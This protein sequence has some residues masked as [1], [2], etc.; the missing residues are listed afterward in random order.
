MDTPR[1]GGKILSHILGVEQDVVD[2]LVQFARP[3]SR[4][5]GRPRVVPR[6]LGIRPADFRGEQLFDAA[7]A[8][9]RA[10]QQ[11]AGFLALEVV[12]RSEPALE[13]VAIRTNEL[14]YDQVSFPSQVFYRAP[15]ISEPQCLVSRTEPGT[16]RP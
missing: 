1:L 2:H 11:A 5:D 13:A 6:R 12:R 8:A 7:I 15:V 16:V 9:E 3:R 10:R 14:K 4:R